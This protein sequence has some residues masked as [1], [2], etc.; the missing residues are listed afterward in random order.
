MWIVSN[1]GFV[2]LICFFFTKII[3]Y[4]RVAPDW[5]LFVVKYFLICDQNEANNWSS[6]IFSFCKRLYRRQLLKQTNT[7]FWWYFFYCLISA[8]HYVQML[9]KYALCSLIYNSSLPI[10]LSFKFPST[11]LL[12]S[13]IVSGISDIRF[14]SSTLFIESISLLQN[15]KH[16]NR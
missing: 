11:T 1:K 15:I 13:S 10:F 4:K 3:S 16:P 9:Q 6:T 12:N 5:I 8:N 14:I 7:N 2:I